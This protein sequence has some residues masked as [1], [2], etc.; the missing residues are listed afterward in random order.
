MHIEYVFCHVLFSIVLISIPCK[1]YLANFD[2]QPAGSCI[3]IYNS[4]A[5]RTLQEINLCDR[6]HTVPLL[7]KGILY[8]QGI[9]KQ[10]NK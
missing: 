3:V 10:M 6:K 7:G 5:R 2:L 8:F 4:K 9:N 1:G